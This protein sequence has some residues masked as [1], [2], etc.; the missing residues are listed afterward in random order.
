MEV[1]CC[2]QAGFGFCG[3]AGPSQ[4]LGFFGNLLG[5]I[6]AASGIDR[7]GEIRQLA[8]QEPVVFPDRAQRLASL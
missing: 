4:R 1:Q 6:E 7:F 5:F 8:A 2:A 3:G